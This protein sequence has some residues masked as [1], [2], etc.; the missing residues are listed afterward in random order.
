MEVAV[1]MVHARATKAMWVKLAIRATPTT[2]AIRAA[3]IVWHPPRVAAMVHARLMAVA[4]A[5]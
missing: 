5:A 2:T 4:H 3:P 1:L